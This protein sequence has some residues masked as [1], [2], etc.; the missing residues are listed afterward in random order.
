[1]RVFIF[2]DKSK[3]IQKLVEASGFLVVRKN[4][5]FIISYGGD[6]TLMKAEYKFPSIPKIILRGNSMVCKKCPPFTN[7]KILEKI[8][9]NKYKI[10][11][12]V[13]LQVKSNDKTL[14]ALNDIIVHNL[15]SRHAIRY[16]IKIDGKS[17]GTEIIGDGIVVATPFGSTGYYRSITDSFF[18]VGIGLAFNNST[19]QADHMVLNEDSVIKLKITRGPAVIYSDNQKEYI[20]LKDNDEVE[21]KKSSHIAKIIYV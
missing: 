1:M 2:G 16:K 17:Q 5:E 10:E 7:K 12:L 20:S 6:G 18:N 14:Y 13:K 15:D 9:K 3:E 8:E 21:I 4:P 19:E 11:E